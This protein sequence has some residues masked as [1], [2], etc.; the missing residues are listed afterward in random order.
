MLG[1]FLTEGECDRAIEMIAF[2]LLVCLFSEYVGVPEVSSSL[3]KLVGI[4]CLMLVHGITA[5][6]A[7]VVSFVELIIE[8]ILILNKT[9]RCLI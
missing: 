5:L 3:T 8:G 4:L 9:K 6:T 1:K 7:G 2:K